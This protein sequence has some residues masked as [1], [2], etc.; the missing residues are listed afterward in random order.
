[1]DYEYKARRLGELHADIWWAHDERAF[2][3]L[4]KNASEMFQLLGFER[5]KA[6]EAGKHVSK[7][8]EEY[9]NAGSADAAGNIAEREFHFVKVLEEQIMVRKILDEDVKTAYYENTWWRHFHYRNYPKIFWPMLRQQMVKYKGW[10]VFFPFRALM[11]IVLAGFRG[12]NIRAKE[13]AEE[14]L[15]KF[16]ELMLKTKGVKYFIQY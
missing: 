16:W 14:R 6:E 15:S 11:C 4:S 12:H 7:A 8:Y 1:M 13:T 5:S 10:N 3:R 9:D 2:E